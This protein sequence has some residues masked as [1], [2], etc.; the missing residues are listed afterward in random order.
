[1]CVRAR[2]RACACIYVHIYGSFTEIGS[3]NEN[4]IRGG[5][6]RHRLR[7][8]LRREQL[9]YGTGLEIMKFMIKKLEIYS[10]V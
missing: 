8:N 7:C 3:A 1:M 2:A 9:K 6:I 5:T 4:L 10:T